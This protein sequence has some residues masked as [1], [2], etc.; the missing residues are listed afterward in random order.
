MLG[1]PQGAA[2]RTVPRG[3]VGKKARAKARES[4]HSERRVGKGARGRLRNSSPANGRPTAT[5]TDA[6]SGPMRPLQAAGKNGQSRAA[7]RTQGTS[8]KRE[9]GEASAVAADASVVLGPCAAGSAPY[10]SHGAPRKGQRAQRVERRAQHAARL[11]GMLRAL[12]QRLS[13][14]PQGLLACHQALFG[15][16]DALVE[17]ALREFSVTVR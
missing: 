13:P 5:R 12:Q 16:R 6:A 2:Y 4:T 14:L 17:R 15:Q 1:T 9:A 11:G 3:V 7:A 10:Q 8:P